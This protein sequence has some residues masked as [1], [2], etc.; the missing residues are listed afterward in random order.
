MA[1]DAELRQRFLAEAGQL[2]ASSLDYAADAR[3]DR[4]DD[5]AAAGRLVR[6][7]DAST[8]RAS[9]SRWRSRTSIR[10]RSRWRTSCA[11]ATRPILTPRPASPAILR[12]GPAELYPEIPD[13]LIV[14]GRRGRRAP[15]DDPRAR[16]A[17]GDGGPDADRRPDARRASRSSSAESG[18]V[19]DDDDLA[20]AEDLALR[21][22]TAIAER[23]AVRGA[24]A[25]RAHAAG[26]PAARSACP[27]CPAGRAHAAYQAGERGAD[28]GGDFYDVLPVES[29]HLV[30]LGDV[31]GKGVEAAALTSL[32]RHSARMAAR[33]DPR[34]ARV[35][36]L[37]N[38]VL[39][40][41]SAPVAGDGGVRA[42]GDQRQPARGS[43]SP[44]PGHPLPLLRRAGGRRTPLGEHGVLLGVA[45]EEDW[46]E[47]PVAARPPA[48]RCSSTPTA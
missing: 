34:P 7:R 45:G 14:A 37:I 38:E 18:R 30:V 32:V 43:P 3:A 23:A 27:S 28:V 5:R 10:R 41:Q 46:T 19:F 33:F 35:L 48:T 8:S 2:L 15:A 13:E 47:T 21:A 12:G 24:G 20:F 25:R 4:A 40:E 31:T 26:Q 39:R 29:G 42:G 6:H 11:G 1:K 22:A 16:H 9:R 44:P 36:S 17:L